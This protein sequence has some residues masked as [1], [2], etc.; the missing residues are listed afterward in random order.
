MDFTIG[1]LFRSRRIRILDDL[2]LNIYEGE[3]LGVVGESG[4]GK[5]TLGK[6]AAGLIR[7]STGRVIYRGKDV[8][9]IKG[10]EWRIF[11]REVQM[12][13]QDPYSSLN[14]A[15]TL[16]T[17]LTRPIIKHGIARGGDAEELAIKLLRR[18]GL[19]PPE[20]FL[21][22]YPHQL[23][24]GQRQRVAI[25]RAISVKPK[26]IIADE[27][28]SMIDVS[29]RAGI[30]RLLAELREE[31]RMS[32]L[33]ITHDLATLRYIGA[34]GRTAVMYLGKLVELAPTEEL[35]EKPLHPYTQLLLEALP[36][37]DP[38]ITRSKRLKELKEIDIPSIANPPSGCR[39]H[40]RC[41][42]AI[43]G[44]CDK[45]V[46]EMKEISRNHFVACHLY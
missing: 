46:P 23:S 14:P 42:L 30:L 39:F 8:W 37:P 40:T 7:P 13:H 22:K 25:A 36:E 43:K 27:P 1:T 10:D 12:I 20:D 45:I 28:V 29:L 15:H 34:K 16:R 32:M 3:T 38:R 11:R 35:I 44:V 9:S 4:S 6:T 21:D 41:P 31:L 24:G 5:T 17:I 26:L 18:V 33:Y 19:V 2:S